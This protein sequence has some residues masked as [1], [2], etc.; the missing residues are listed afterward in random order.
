MTENKDLSVT[1][2][3]MFYGLFMED[4]FTFLVLCIGP[5]RF[6]KILVNFLSFQRIIGGSCHRDD[7]DLVRSIMEYNG[8]PWF[9]RTDVPN[10]IIPVFPSLKPDKIANDPQDHF[11][12]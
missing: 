1:T 8:V 2:L 6:L 5:L 3:V 7:N 10:T 12:R 11:T 9:Y 4:S